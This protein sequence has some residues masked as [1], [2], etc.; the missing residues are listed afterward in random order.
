MGGVG[1]GVVV[2]GGMEWKGQERNVDGR[3]S[4]SIKSV[5]IVSMYQTSAEAYKTTREI[6]SVSS[7]IGFYACTCVCL[8]VCVL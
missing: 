6:Y 3:N 8:C 7:S 5:L 1:V 4:Y 2:V